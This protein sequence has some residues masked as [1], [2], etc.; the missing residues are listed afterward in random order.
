[1]MAQDKVKAIILVGGQ[2]T[3]LRPLTYHTPKPMVPVLNIPFLEHIIL[4]LKEHG[5]LDIILAQHYLAE[6]ME[7]YLGNGNKLGVKLYYV[8]E[9][10]PRGTAGAVKNAESFLD[11]TL[12]VLN[13]D[14]YHNRNFTEI[15]NFHWQNKAK[16]T[17]VLTP[18]EDPTVYGVVETD[19]NGRVKSFV[20]KPK[21][22]EVTTNMINAGTYV[23]ESD[24]LQQV[25]PDI[26]YSLERELFPEM[27]AKGQPLYAYVSKNY[28]MDTGTPEKYLQLHRDLLSGKCDGY[29]IEKDVNI[30]IGCDIHPSVQFNGRVVI[31][32][33]CIIARDVRLSGP[34]VIGSGCI[35][36]E[37]TVISDSIIWHDVTINPRVIIKSSIIAHKCVLGDDS[38]LIDAVLG[39]HV[40]ISELVKLKPG[41]RVMPGE[42]VKEG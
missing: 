16:V 37:N 12:L 33:N 28:W 40:T 29:S 41:S 20:E 27:I 15:L 34:V 24:I 23:I 32:N 7:E 17:I 35:I 5:I 2:G 11:G 31:G 1:M 38:Y 8:T 3:R 39:D 4:N 42:I 36:R 26:K 19:N 30:G 6:S 22:E 13:G 14:I 9:D 21:P 18:V 25:P 10:E